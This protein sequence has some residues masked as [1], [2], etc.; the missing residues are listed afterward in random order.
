MRIKLTLEPLHRDAA[1]SFNYNYSF[2]SMIYQKLAESSPDYASFLHEDGYTTGKKKFKYFTFSRPWVA[3]QQVRNGR[4]YILSGPVFWQ[5]T[6]PVDDFLNN[7]VNGLFQQP[8]L[9]LADSEVTARFRLIEVETLPTPQLSDH[10]SFICLSPI[11]VAAKEEVNGQPRKLYVRA[12]DTRFGELINRNLLEKYCALYGREPQQ[13]QLEFAFDE[14]YIVR[15]GG[16]ERI[17]KL[18]RF[19]GIDIRGY[20]APFTVRGSKEL[21]RLGYECGFGNANS[22]GFGMAAFPNIGA[23]EH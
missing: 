23:E 17:S 14:D 20:F 16:V 13:S 7:F 2:S 9:T 8:L 15:R 19:K 1:L 10:T 3:R 12:D 4:I 5:I 11:T 18:I 21:I 6:S 22:Q